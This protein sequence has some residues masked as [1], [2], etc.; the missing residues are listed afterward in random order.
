MLTKTRRILLALHVEYWPFALLAA[1]LTA[2][3]AFS[4]HPARAAPINAAAATS[5]WASPLL[6]TDGWCVNVSTIVDLMASA[7]GRYTPAERSQTRYYKVIHADSVDST[8]AL[9]V[10]YGATGVAG[11]LTCDPAGAPT[12]TTGSI[13]T[14]YGA[15]ETVLISRMA[16]GTLPPYYA[17]ASGGSILTCVTVGY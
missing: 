2:I 8:A 14:S 16:D 5:E 1:G 7:P 3:L 9:C 15:S 17:V 10:A 6:A 4:P 11:A 13:L 12:T